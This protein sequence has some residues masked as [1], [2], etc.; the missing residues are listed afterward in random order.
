MILHEVLH[1]PVYVRS[2]EQ[3]F[4]HFEQGRQIAIAAAKETGNDDSIARAERAPPAMWYP[5]RYNDTAGWI[6]LDVAPDRIM[7]KLHLRKTRKVFQPA[8]GTFEKRCDVLDFHPF[9]E[10]SGEIHDEIVKQLRSALAE[11][12]LKTMYVDVEA[13]EQLKPLMRWREFM[14]GLIATKK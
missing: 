12:P 9:G 14:E 10:S 13:L 6:L 11:P 4:A 7:G 3:H 1:I 8:K 2:S 5:W